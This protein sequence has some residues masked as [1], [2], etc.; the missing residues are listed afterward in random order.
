MH[1]F[2]MLAVSYSLLVSASRTKNLRSGE[3]LLQNIIGMKAHGFPNFKKLFQLEAVSNIQALTSPSKMDP[4]KNYHSPPWTC[5]CGY[6]DI[7]SY[8]EDRYTNNFEDGYN[9]KYPYLKSQTYEPPQSHQAND[10][11]G[12]EPC[13][14]PYPPYYRQT[15]R[16]RDELYNP[17]F[18][19]DEYVPPR[20]RVEEY[21]RTV[22]WF[23]EHLVAR[24]GRVVKEN[25][26]RLWWGLRRTTAL[27]PHERPTRQRGT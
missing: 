19:E 4:I 2:T 9:H 7:D 15:Y 13:L 27:D 17:R 14:R 5:R 12:G 21:T 22:D 24:T 6:Y 11:Y 25:T 18:F 8:Y 1:M 23:Y 10:Y 3:V 20:F 16:A 26:V